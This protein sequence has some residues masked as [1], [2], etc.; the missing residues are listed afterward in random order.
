MYKVNDKDK[1]LFD[2]DGFLIV[3]R[4]I[5]PASLPPLHRA[6]DDLFH[7]RFETGVRPDEVNW[8]AETGDPGLTRTTSPRWRASRAPCP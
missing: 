6:F 7:G 3:D 4:L 1:A 8:Q 2:Q 5:A